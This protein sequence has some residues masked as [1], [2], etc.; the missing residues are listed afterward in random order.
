MTA[1]LAVLG[2]AISAAGAIVLAFLGAFETRVTLTP[3]GT[4]PVTIGLRADDL[5]TMV[6]VMVTLVALAI[7]VYSVG[8]MK[9]D[10]RYPAFAALVGLFTLA[11]LTVVLAA[12]LL[13]LYVG[14]EI[15]GVCSYFLIGHHW[16][17]PHATA[18]AIKSFLMTRFGDVGFLFGIFVLGVAAGSFRITDVIAAVPAMTS[19]TVLTGALLL[20][21]GVVGKAAQFP[22]H[23]WLPDAMAGPAPV[24][25]L[26]HA[27]TMVAAGA[28]VVALLY[29]VF[30]SAPLALDV[31]AVVAV[32][33]MIGAALA[34][35][36]TDDL[37]RVL[38]YSTI[39]QL[40]VMFAALAVGGRTQA[41]AH[42]LS[43][44]A[45]KALLFLCSGAV[46]IAVGSNL[47]TRMG[48]LRRR[49]PLSFL[50]MTVGFAALAGI[51][52]TAGFFSKDAVVASAEHHWFVF[53]ALLLT[54]GLT[55][56][57]TTR[58]WLRTFFGSGPD[59]REAPKLMTVPLVLLA[60]VA[61]LLGF[62]GLWFDELRPELLSAV[63]SVVLAGVGVAA[64]YLV[65]RRDPAKDPVDSLGR[66]RGVFGSA[67]GTDTLYERTIARG[68]MR[69]ADEVVRVDDSVVGRTVRG[70]G[71]GTRS[72]GGLLRRAQNGNAQFYVTALLAGVVVIAVGVVILR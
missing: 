2:T 32:I 7:Q 65:W 43:H 57:Y 38:A 71:R 3:T 36:V 13:M 5:S 58:A 17:K 54:V 27:A 39:S 16:E 19:G 48:G 60:V 10:V 47:M 29:P 28:Y 23:S 53:V 64:V 59:V 46:I 62:A 68:V 22:L 30:L 63:L 44:A 33:S 31:L 52:P 14:W 72:L 12:D 50:T 41:I 55:A 25:A 66:L 11:M 56:A 6:A 15:M 34:A 20:L 9:H 37:K 40:S 35:L 67:F 1:P 49:M 42:L 18:A 21:V 70:T 61:L 24:S 26:I 69:V 45:F 8:Y 51:P 4:I